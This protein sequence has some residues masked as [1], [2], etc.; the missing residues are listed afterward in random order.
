MSVSFPYCLSCLSFTEKP[1]IFRAPGKVM[2][3]LPSSLKAKM[4][5][6]IGVRQHSVVV[7]MC[8]VT[9]TPKPKISWNK[10]GQEIAENLL[11]RLG[12]LI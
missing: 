8:D 4:G 10:N 2:R 6:Y 7:I 3:I 9:G 11:V 12:K 1:K 5:Q